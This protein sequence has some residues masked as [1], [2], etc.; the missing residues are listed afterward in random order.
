MHLGPHAISG[1]R[2]GPC[3]CREENGTFIANCSSRGLINIS[4]DIP[5]WTNHLIM[6]NNSL[7]NITDSF[8]RFYNLTYLNIASCNIVSIG[9]KALVNLKLLDTLD[10]SENTE[11]GFYSLG[12]AMNGLTSL[13]VLKANSI[14]HPY[15]VCVCI[16]KEMLQ[17]LN[18]TRLKEIHVNDNRI[19]IFQPGALQYL[20]QSIKK[21]SAKNNRFTIG[22]YLADVA[23]LINLEEL[24]LSGNLQEPNIYSTIPSMD[25][26]LIQE[27]C[28]T[29]T[30]SDKGHL[31]F[32]PN[33]KILNMRFSA[34]AYYVTKID[35]GTNSI[36]NVSL[37]GNI[38]SKWEGPVLN[39]ENIRHLDL[40][41]NL[42]FWINSDFFSN[43]SSLET[44]DI[45]QNNL[46]L[47]IARDTNGAVFE[48][49][50]KLK[51]LNIQETYLIYLPEKIFKGL[52]N[53]QILDLSRNLIRSE[54]LFISLQHMNQLKFINFTFNH[55]QWFS[56]DFMNEL[57]KVGKKSGSLTIDLR[58]NP[59]FCN[60]KNLNFLR[61]LNS[62]PYVQFQYFEQY[63]CIFTDGTTMYFNQSKLIFTKLSQQCDTVIG[64]IISCLFAT[65]LF[66]SFVF[67]AI[68]YKFRWKL[69]YLYYAAKS[70]RRLNYLHDVFEFDAFISYSEDAR[71]FVDQTMRL[72]VE[73]EAGLKLCLHNRDFLPSLPIA[74]G[75]VTAV[76]TS[77]KTVLVMSPDFVKS[78]WCMYEMNMADMESQHTGRDVLLI[79]L[80]K[81]I[82]YDQ[83]PSTVMYQIKSHTYIE[84][85]NTD[86]DSEEMVTFWDNFVRAI[87]CP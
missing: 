3:D 22:E 84:Y 12:I 83:I 64:Q 71:L 15:A 65:I 59:L 4:P 85:P 54:Y 51:Y 21:V 49:L 17:H 87:Q 39:V 5:D 67:L 50:N 2:C 81:H 77:R 40:S 14:V 37:R 72:K 42:C 61:W 30:N 69:R 44:L 41:Q 10:I 29:T 16:S 63:L 55:I 66:L 31:R 8:T 75:I 11:L 36:Q 18:K 79:L 28:D 60:C 20:P 25:W 13:T 53:C 35:L 58:E 33:L 7:N 86:D 19:E 47:V 73:E 43:F 1:H 57:E 52:K 62:T 68:Y 70:S 27:A 24:D 76:K 38:L 9:N 80:Y 78:Y 82:K 74:E 45:A 6:F 26:V 56:F 32:P 23:H 48:T 34:L 46:E